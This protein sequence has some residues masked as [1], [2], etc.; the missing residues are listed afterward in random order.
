MAGILALAMWDRER[1]VSLVEAVTG[2]TFQCIRE[3]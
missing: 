1:S 3:P 2:L